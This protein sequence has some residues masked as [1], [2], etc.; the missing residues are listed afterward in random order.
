MLKP[1]E[2]YNNPTHEFTLFKKVIFNWQIANNR[3]YIT[4]T[5]GHRHTIYFG[6]T[7]VEWEEDDSVIY[8]ITIWRLNLQI[9]LI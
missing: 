5:N 4:Q 7:K 9:A 3:W 1:S 6:F 8:N 2:K